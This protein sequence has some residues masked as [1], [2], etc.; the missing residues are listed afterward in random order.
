[1]PERFV[2]RK[3]AATIRYCVQN[4]EPREYTISTSSDDEVYVL[5]EHGQM[6]TYT[7]LIFDVHALNVNKEIE[8]FLDMENIVRL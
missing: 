7:S 8:E 1:M 5:G 4:E 3:C 6:L 2:F